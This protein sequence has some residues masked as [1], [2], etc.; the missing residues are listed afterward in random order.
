MTTHEQELRGCDRDRLWALAAG[1]LEEQETPALEA[2]LAGCSDC[3]ERLVAIQADVEALGC[4]AEGARSPDELAQQVLSR[5]RGLQARARRLRWL[6]LSA[7]LLSILVGGFYTAHR[8]G[9]SALAR[10]D[11]WALEHAIQ[12]IQNREGRYPANEDELVRA[13]ARLQSPDVRV[14]EQGRPLDHWGHPFRY[15]CPG[16]RVPGLFDLW[17]LGPNGL[18]ERGGPDDQTNWR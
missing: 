1:A 10:R 13:L 3:R 12:S 17:G 6:A 4:F 14:D 7:L 16:E 2:H 9:E 18:D 5:S 15:R 8:L 11:L